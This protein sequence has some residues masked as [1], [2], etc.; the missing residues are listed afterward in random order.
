[1]ETFSF[2][3]S[4]AISVAALKLHFPEE[5]ENVNLNISRFDDFAK[6][7]TFPEFVRLLLAIDQIQWEC[8][9]LIRK[10]HPTFDSEGKIEQSVGTA[11]GNCIIKLIDLNLDQQI[12]AEIRNVMIEFLENRVAIAGDLGVG[13]TTPIEMQMLSTI[14][15]MRSP[16]IL[17]TVVGYLAI[18]MM[19][20]DFKPGKLI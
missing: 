16:I 8:R 5:T 11:L 7:S 6:S 13:R 14:E 4:A 3:T 19:I 12:L 9:I 2:I 17:Q 20:G 1:M 15:E 10:K 18:R